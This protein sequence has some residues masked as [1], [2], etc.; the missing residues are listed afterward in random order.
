MT[1]ISTYDQLQITSRFAVKLTITFSHKLCDSCS[2]QV[3][4]LVKFVGNDRLAVTNTIAGG[5]GALKRKAAAEQQYFPN[6]HINPMLIYVDR[7]LTSKIMKNVN[8]N[9]ILIEQDKKK[10][11]I[12][13]G[14]Q[15]ENVANVVQN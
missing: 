7:S 10:C 9:S 14:L 5:R 12:N 8:T 15:L 2:K 3:G 13:R 6:A 4:S 11:I 1:L